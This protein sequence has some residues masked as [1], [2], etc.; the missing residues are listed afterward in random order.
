MDTIQ[1]DVFLAEPSVSDFKGFLVETLPN[2]KVDLKI[3][4]SAKVP[5]GIDTIVFGLPGLLNEYKWNSG[6]ITTSGKKATALDWPST[7]G[8]LAE[9][10]SSLKLAC[11]SE[12]DEDVQRVATQ[13]L[14]WG[15]DRNKNVGATIDIKNLASNNQLTSYLNKTKAIF[16]AK[17]LEVG[18]LKEICYTGSMWT[19]IYA[20]NS[21]DGLPIYDSRVA[22]G[23][24]GLVHLFHKNQKIQSKAADQF[25]SFSVPAGTNW[26][27]N[28]K[29]GMPLGGI[30]K[31]NKNDAIWSTDTL[32]LSWLMDAVLNCSDLFLEQGEFTTRKHG[33]E[34]SLFLLGYD[35]RA[36]LN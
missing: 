35:L 26:D 4:K 17:T 9:L 12:N 13:I 22:M 29:S 11:A 5:G 14:Q 25:L 15:G 36:I 20:L 6:F 34:A 31:I 2:L 16:E 1:K 10:S 23:M 28:K 3:K 7:K 8:L 19:K 32:K 24:V 18:L 33:F 27:R 30:T 21:D